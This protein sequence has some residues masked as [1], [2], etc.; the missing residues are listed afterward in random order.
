M[1]KIE[2]RHTPGPWTLDRKTGTV[3][4]GPFVIAR[5][6]YKEHVVMSVRTSDDNAQLIVRAPELLEENERLRAALADI[7]R[8]DYSDPLCQRTPEQRARDALAAM[9]GKP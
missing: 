1:K 9:K 5:V 2:S 3:T 4:S 7:A 8:G 6:A